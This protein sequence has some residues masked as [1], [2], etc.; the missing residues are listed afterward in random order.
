MPQLSRSV[1]KSQERC[2]GNAVGEAPP[3]KATGLGMQTWEHGW[4]RRPVRDSNILQRLQ[5][6]GC[7]PGLGWEGGSPLE[8]CQEK[9]YNCLTHHTQGLGLEQDSAA[10]RP[11]D[12]RS[13]AVLDTWTHSGA[14]QAEKLTH[15][16]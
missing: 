9:P 2:L 1:R 4:P 8:P 16:R 6:V 14:I 13:G 11:S 10:R 15:T 3:K 7:A 12:A 5:S